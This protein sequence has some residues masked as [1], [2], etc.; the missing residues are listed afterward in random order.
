[1]LFIGSAQLIGR[2]FLILSKQHLT[3]SYVQIVAGI[4]FLTLVPADA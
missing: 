2:R 1:M 3:H 4:F